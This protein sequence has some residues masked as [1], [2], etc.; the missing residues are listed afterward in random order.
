MMCPRRNYTTREAL[1]LG[2]GAQF[3]S[4]LISREIRRNANTA[5]SLRGSVERVARRDIADASL[6]TFASTTQQRRRLRHLR[7]T[8]PFD[9]SLLRRVAILKGS[10]L[11]FCLDAN[12][13]QPTLLLGDRFVSLDCVL[14]Q[15][16]RCIR[17][18]FAHLPPDS[19]FLT[20]AV[21]GNTRL[22]RGVEQVVDNMAV[23]CGL[24]Y[25]VL[26]PL[27]EY[28]LWGLNELPVDAM[29][30]YPS[31]DATCYVS[32]AESV[33]HFFLRGIQQMTK[34]GWS[35][36]AYLFI[37]RVVCESLLSSFGVGLFW[38][39]KFFFDFRRVDT[40]VPF[41][42][43]KSVN[44]NWV[45]GNLIHAYVPSPVVVAHEVASILVYKH[46]SLAWKV[47]LNVRDY[48]M[49]TYLDTPI[50]ITRL[51]P[52]QGL[53]ELMLT[54][55]QKIYF[56][57]SEVQLG[58]RRRVLRDDNA[59]AYSRVLQVGIGSYVVV[60]WNVQ[61]R[62]LTTGRRV[63]AFY[64]NKGWWQVAVIFMSQPILVESSLHGPITAAVA[65]Q[66]VLV[67]LGLCLLSFG[68]GMLHLSDV[69][70]ASLRLD[71]LLWSTLIALAAMLVDVYVAGP[72]MN[73]CYTILSAWS[74]MTVFQTRDPRL[75]TCLCVYNYMFFLT[76]N[77]QNFF[78]QEYWLTLVCRLLLL[79]SFNM[80]LLK[81]MT[82]ARTRWIAVA[83]V[84]C[85][86]S[87][88][89]GMAGVA[90]DAALAIQ[91]LSYT[92]YVPHLSRLDIGMWKQIALELGTSVRVA[93][94]LLPAGRDPRWFARHV[95][96]E[97]YK[98][99]AAQLGM[100]RQQAM[101]AARRASLHFSGTE[102]VFLFGQTRNYSR[103][104][105]RA[106]I[107][108]QICADAQRAA[109]WLPERSRITQLTLDIEHASMSALLCAYGIVPDV[110]P[111]HISEV[112]SAHITNR[113][114]C[115]HTRLALACTMWIEDICADVTSVLT[116]SDVLNGEN[117]SSVYI[118]AY[119][120][121]WGASI[122]DDSRHAPTTCLLL[123]ELENMNFSQARDCVAEM[124][125]VFLTT[126]LADR[127]CH[128]LE[129]YGRAERILH[130][131]FEDAA[132][133]TWVAVRN[134]SDVACSLVSSLYF[135]IFDV[136]FNPLEDDDR[137]EEAL[138]LLEEPSAEYHYEGDVADDESS[139]DSS[140]NSDESSVVA[141]TECSC[142]C[143]GDT[144]VGV[145]MLSDCDELL[146]FSGAYEEFPILLASEFPAML[147][148]AFAHE[149]EPVMFALGD[150]VVK[151]IS[152]E[153]PHMLWREEA[154]R[155][156]L[157]LVTVEFDS[158]NKIY[159]PVVEYEDI[160]IF[161]REFDST[162]FISSYEANDNYRLR[163]EFDAL[164]CYS[165]D[166]VDANADLLVQG[167][168]RVGYIPRRFAIK[169]FKAIAFA[170]EDSTGTRVPCISWRMLELVDS[171]YEHKSP[172]RNVRSRSDIEPRRSRSDT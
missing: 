114:H 56:T 157:N 158:E 13:V 125:I 35:E 160:L 149:H 46:M 99:R 14:F 70:S 11:D 86:R 63:K 41:V 69:S 3:M 71:L 92:N 110:C 108:E 95:S 78:T 141:R 62:F 66:R 77:V 83:L 58:A 106:R 132:D 155:T 167:T 36:G 79:A 27:V 17:L 49:I 12:G 127:Q 22:I 33:E 140:I 7:M 53:T 64:R 168:R 139:E 96:V 20:L 152:D 171:R 91:S 104:A 134:A 72:I 8:R 142:S 38:L 24:D 15:L 123:D 88:V 118:Y 34:L 150:V 39:N 144:D 165:P 131:R 54:Q 103:V 31:A 57:S 85:I 105:H 32:I 166:S 65:D 159:Y 93:M 89:L 101:D 75:A 119:L 161:D 25:N 4:E 52:R 133:L 81:G 138:A 9:D 48:R 136:G 2:G 145:T 16:M 111:V 90:I 126:R 18:D 19:D 151:G 87:L 121:G 80:V 68:I 47:G 51:I 82:I 122:F 1:P 10:S 156:C 170:R 154:L 43:H 45:R 107:S 164:L 120:S 100:H 23:K 94:S 76:C 42:W 117:M 73:T 128:L 129:A 147:R 172:I 29:I 135:S 97:R 84:E 67:A 6:R 146:S 102:H 37:F 116:W 109:E 21:Y 124:S 61:M 60:P 153:V 5:A 112:L 115:I 163:N 44:R 130:R 30:E 59:S 26:K 55:V 113:P 169:R 143:G 50:R 28:H 74:T 148:T 98:Y 40:H 162:L 137:M